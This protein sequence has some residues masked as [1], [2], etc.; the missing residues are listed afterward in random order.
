MLFLRVPLLLL[1]TPLSFLKNHNSIDY[2]MVSHVRVTEDA[3][4]VVEHFPL[5]VYFVVKSLYILAHCNLGRLDSQRVFGA[6]QDSDGVFATCDRVIP[7]RKRQ[8]L[9]TPRLWLLYPRV[10]R[11]LMLNRRLLAVQ[12]LTLRKLLNRY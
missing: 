8:D 3:F 1:E 5:Q 12:I 4:D 10:W 11:L 7:L 9:Q 6:W 2:A